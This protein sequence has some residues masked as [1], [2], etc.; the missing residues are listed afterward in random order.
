MVLV[1]GGKKRR[2]GEVGLEQ[3]GI[4]GEGGF[5]RSGKAPLTK[6][7]GEGGPMF[8]KRGARTYMREKE[9][10]EEREGK[11]KLINVAKS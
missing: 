8:F 10:K 9:L 6:T 11:K 2:I 5:S 3:K 1:P 4:R 7:E